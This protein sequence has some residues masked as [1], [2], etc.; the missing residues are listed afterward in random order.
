MKVAVSATGGSL[1]AHVDPRFG[2]CPYFVIVDTDTMEFEAIPNISSGAISGAGIQAAQTIL[3]KGI[4]AVITGS[5]GPNA[6]QALSAAGIRVYVGAFGTVQDAVESFKSGRLQ[7]ATVSGPM[8]AGI[9]RGM[10]MGRG[11]GKGR[12]MGRGMGRGLGGFSDPPFLQAPM[13]PQIPSPP[14]SREEEV[15]MLEERMKSLQ[16]ELERIKKKLDELKSS[17]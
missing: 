17:C 2:R 7:E 3:N 1:E 14:M 11:M 6:C 13:N 15:S 8:G 9:G 5:V 12:G 10:G 16:Q 4:K